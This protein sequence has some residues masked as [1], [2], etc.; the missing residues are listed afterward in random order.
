MGELDARLALSGM[1]G[2]AKYSVLC[3]GDGSGSA[4]GLGT[5]S[6]E[7]RLEAL[8]F[9]WPG[10]RYEN[11]F[12]GAIAGVGSSLAAIAIALLPRGGTDGGRPEAQLLNR[13]GG[14]AS[15]RGN[16]PAETIADCVEGGAGAGAEGRIVQRLA[17]SGSALHTSAV[18]RCWETVGKS[19]CGASQ[20]ANLPKP[21][22]RMLG[23]N[24][25]QG[26]AAQMPGAFE[27]SSERW[28]RR[29]VECAGA[30]ECSR[31]VLSMHLPRLRR[32]GDSQHPRFLKASCIM[33]LDIHMQ[34]LL[35]VIITS[36]CAQKST[37]PVR[38]HSSA[39]D[40]WRA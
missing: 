1:R 40:A 39:Q 21:T 23:W 28:S 33:T 26:R 22:D 4:A 38:L 18:A 31:S 24:S 7:A 20:H 5:G 37:H 12:E 35:A 36:I 13:T 8:R 30:A 11:M 32:R 16:A 27:R 25:G 3:D 2:D 34:A 6:G 19:L 15:Q 17:A 14:G 9:A 10:R 29:G